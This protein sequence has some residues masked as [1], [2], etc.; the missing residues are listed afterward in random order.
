MNSYSLKLS[1][2]EAKDV[3]TRVEKRINTQPLYFAD[4][5]I[6]MMATK[7]IQGQIRGYEAEP[8]K[9]QYLNDEHPFQELSFFYDYKDKFKKENKNINPTLG[10]LNQEIKDRRELRK[11]N[12]KINQLFILILVF[13]FFFIRFRLF[14]LFIN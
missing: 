5:C 1:I 7:V 4:L 8:I 11:R 9:I 13:G 12:E 10:E 3:I 2:D 6:I 14:K